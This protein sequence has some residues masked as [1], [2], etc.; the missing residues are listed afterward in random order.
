VRAAVVSLVLGIAVALACAGDGADRAARP[1]PRA[2]EAPV[3]RP[4]GRAALPR[5]GHLTYQLYAVEQV[6]EEA[7]VDLLFRNGTSRNFE[8]VLVRVIAL[9]A[10][11]TRAV[12]DAPLG[13]MSRRTSRRHRVYFSDLDFQVDEILVE[14]LY[15]YP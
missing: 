9:G 1:D 10:E 2:D 4:M 12:A 7:Q 6:E 8:A 11:G 13:S 3:A 15:T 14:V 5:S